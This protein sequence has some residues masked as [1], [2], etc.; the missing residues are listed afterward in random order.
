MTAERLTW[1]ET[2]DAA[3]SELQAESG[4]AAKAKTTRRWLFHRGVVRIFAR[5]A[6]AI[7]ISLVT[8]GL[9]MA[10]GIDIWIVS[11]AAALPY[12]LMPMVSVG[13][14]W[15]A[16]GYR[17]RRGESIAGHLLRVALGASAVMGSAFLIALLAGLAHTELF[18]WLT[19]A[20]A[21]TLI[22]LHAN[23][24]G[25]VR[26]ATRRGNLSDKPRRIGDRRSGG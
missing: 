23:Y 18:G 20:N 7:V 12:V 22:A 8:V 2:S 15:L 9:C 10:A 13:G 14:V 26:T 17:F 25:I 3:A 19:T 24:L 4:P 5:T 11:L 21:L 1:A 16:G 6:D